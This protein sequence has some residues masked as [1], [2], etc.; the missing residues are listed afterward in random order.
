M[1]TSYPVFAFEGGADRMVDFVYSEALGHW[2]QEVRGLRWRKSGRR[3][4]LASG[5]PH[6]YRDVLRLPGG[7]YVFEPFHWRTFR[8]I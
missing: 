1:T 8:Y 2:N 5:E 3:D 7:E 4:D 6:G